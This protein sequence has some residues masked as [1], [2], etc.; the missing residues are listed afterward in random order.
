MKLYT[1]YV[2]PH[3]ETAS[4]AWSPW[5]I[6]DRTALEKV[7]EKAVKMVTGLKGITYEERCAEL[8]LET[9]ERRRDIQDMV[10]THRILCRP[11]DGYAAGILH[12]VRGD[13]GS[14][15]TRQTADPLN[16]IHQYA[17]TE[18]RRN[19][20][21]VRVVEKWNKLSTTTKSASNSGSFK[22]LLRKEWTDE[23]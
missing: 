8:G 1:Q 20:F 19:V 10:E 3:L 2:R 17:R 4:P 12:Q 6:G 9:L 22:N 23:K 21:G 18:I 11:N 16:L 15:R 7:Q 5:T 13:T 14:A